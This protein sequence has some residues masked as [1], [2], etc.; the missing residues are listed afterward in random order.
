MTPELR[1]DIFD[2]WLRIAE[3]ASGDS[4]AARAA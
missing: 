3:R 4:M 2:D 1:T